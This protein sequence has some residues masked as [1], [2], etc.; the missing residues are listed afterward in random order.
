MPRPYEFNG[1]SALRS[2]VLEIPISPVKGLS[3]SRTRKIAP[4]NDSAQ[5]SSEVMTTR[6]VCANK[7]KLKKNR[8][9]PK[10]QYARNGAGIE[11]PAWVN[12]SSRVCAPSMKAAMA[13]DCRE[14]CVSLAG[15]RC[16]SSFSNASDSALDS[17]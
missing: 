17:K 10:N 9:Q 13:R 16:S 7:V 4:A 1:K 15:V 12:S 3:S 14:R 11:P 5:T 8:A 6:L 2:V